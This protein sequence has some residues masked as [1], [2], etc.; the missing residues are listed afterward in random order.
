MKKPNRKADGSGGWVKMD[1]ATI[2][3]L[4]LFTTVVLAIAT[5]Y[6]AWQSRRQVQTQ[7]KAAKDTLDT[8]RDQMKQDL[9]LED[10]RS[11]EIAKQ[12]RQKAYTQL[13]GRKIEIID[14]YMLR[15]QSQIKCEGLGIL[16]TRYR[17][18][19]IPKMQVLHD[20]R[21]ETPIE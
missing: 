12:T 6:M 7:S 17:S 5:A 15:V 1:E 20:A 10:K 19:S 9:Q 3:L 18:K 4:G 21:S 16:M 2:S 8:M 13:E 14:L 11:K